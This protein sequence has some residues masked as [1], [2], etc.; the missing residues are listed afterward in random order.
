MLDP[1]EPVMRRLI[2][3]WPEIKAPRVTEILRDDYGYAGRSIWS[4][5]GWRR[6]GR[7]RC[8]RRS[9]RAIGR[10]R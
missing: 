8:G 7:E 4:A 9:G 6:C 1:L 2:E 3:E 10:G 5:S